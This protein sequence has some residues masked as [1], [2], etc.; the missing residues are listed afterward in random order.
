MKALLSAFSIVIAGATVAATG[1]AQAASPGACAA[2][3]ADAEAGYPSFC[4][5]PQPP[6]DVR[7]TAE[8]KKAVVEARL[9]ARSLTRATAR[10]QWSLSPGQAEPFAAQARAQATP[11]PPMTAPGGTEEFARRAREEATP[12]P[13]PH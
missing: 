10:M 9:A 5:I 8:F 3:P 13:R 1:F 6:T 7:T 4:S 2:T 12:P 11:P